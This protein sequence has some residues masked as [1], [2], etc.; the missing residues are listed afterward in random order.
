MLDVERTQRVVRRESH[1]RCW[2]HVGWTVHVIASSSRLSRLVALS[3]TRYVSMLSD[4]DPKSERDAIE[5]L[6]NS[7]SSAADTDLPIWTI[8]RDS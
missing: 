4:V 7:A 8:C 6:K 1:L 5:I 3:M 2:C